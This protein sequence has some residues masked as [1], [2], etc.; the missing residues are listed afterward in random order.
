MVA[1]PGKRKGRGL[2]DE[3]GKT[4]SVKT[5]RLQVGLKHGATPGQIMG[6]ITNE[7]GIE[8][9]FV[10]RIEINDDHSL[11]DL[12]D[13]MPKE[14]YRHLQRVYVCGQPLMLTNIKQVAGKTV[15]GT[16]SKGKKPK[17]KKQKKRSSSESD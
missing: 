5:Y 9:Q 16:D 3:Q 17:A 8:G 12:P 11:V 2:T 4:I 6:A 15:K 13:G 10:G 14:V 1:E 7:A